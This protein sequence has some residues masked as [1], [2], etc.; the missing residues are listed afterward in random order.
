[1]NTESDKYQLDFEFF[2][3]QF[4]FFET[5]KSKEWSFFDNAGGSF[6]CRQVIDRLVHFYR[7]N[8]VQPYAH[9]ALAR[10]AHDQLY[11]GTQVIADI[12]GVPVK[13]LT[14]GASSTQN[15]NTLAAACVGYVKE[16][17]EFIIS[18]QDHEANIGGWERAAMNAKAK[19]TLWPVNSK[20]GELEVETLKSLINEKTKVI[21]LTHC[22]NV[23]G[24]INPIKEIVEVAKTVGAKVV[25]DGVSYAPHNWPDIL[26]LN[27]DAYGFSTY[28]TYGTHQGVLYVKEDFMDL[29]K[30]QCH[31]F[32][33]DDPSY[34]LNS[35]GHDHACVA[36]LAGLK[37]FIEELYLHHF[38]EDQKSLKE[39]ASLVSKI[40][41]D[42]EQSQ[43]GDFLNEL[44]SMPVRV[45]GRTKMENRETNIAFIPDSMTP[46]E[47]ADK[48]A[49]K[50]V[51]AS[52]SHFDCVRMMERLGVD[53]K[54]GVL[55]VSFAPYNS[56][57]DTE[58]II[59]A[60]K[61]IL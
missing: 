59:N 40:L 31:Y 50:G 32:Y 21:S 17:D 34:K 9:N 20:T 27:I 56:K 1:M 29:L 46:G 35:S 54:E 44:N 23:V 33:E 60:L 37:D 7:E 14:L 43:C 45:I 36:A 4:P 52:P 51:A 24:T 57:E 55:R 49:E 6:P 53:T 10:A 15:F 48:L 3:K 39:K 18:E 42:Y 41:F 38:G 2:R 12:L 22:S 8:K 25:V 58:K 11:E 28:K 26:D 5:G 19:F 30:V 47:L 16:G 13:T 61:E